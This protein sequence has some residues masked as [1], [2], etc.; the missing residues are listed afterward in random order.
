[1]SINEIEKEWKETAG[2]IYGEDAFYRRLIIR[3]NLIFK[4]LL[5]IAKKLNRIEWDK[6]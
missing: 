2:R 1:M 4:L 6:Q 5:D 3:Q